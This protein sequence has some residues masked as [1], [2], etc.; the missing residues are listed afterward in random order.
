MFAIS[1]HRYIAICLGKAISLERLLP[2]NSS[3][4]ILKYLATVSLIKSQEI[5]FSLS[6]LNS[7]IIFSA[8]SMVMGLCVKEALAT[9]LLNTPSNSRMLESI[10][11]AILER[12]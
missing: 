12:I 1:L 5:T 9:T 6:Y 4:L 2:D 10:L 3:L 7:L 11:L 8:S